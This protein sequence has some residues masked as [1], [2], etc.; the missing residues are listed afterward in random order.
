MVEFR[1]QPH[2][3]A[4]LPSKVSDGDESKIPEKRV[5]VPRNPLFN[6]ELIPMAAVFR[7]SPIHEE[8]YMVR[9][10]GFTLTLEPGQTFYGYPRGFAVRDVQEMSDGRYRA[11]L[12]GY[13]EAQS[14]RTYA[15]TA[16]HMVYTKHRQGRGYGDHPP[17]YHPAALFEWTVRYT[18]MLAQDYKV[19]AVVD[20]SGLEAII[21]QASDVANKHAASAIDGDDW[22]ELEDA[23]YAADSFGEALTTWGGIPAVVASRAGAALMSGNYSD[24]ITVK[25]Q[26]QKH[27]L[28]KADLAWRISWGI[29]PFGWRYSD[30]SAYKTLLGLPGTSVLLMPDARIGVQMGATWF[31]GER[32]KFE[33]SPHLG[34]DAY[35]K[36]SPLAVVQQVG[37]KRFVSLEGSAWLMW[38]VKGRFNERMDEVLNNNNSFVGLTA[39]LR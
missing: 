20:T 6:P 30:E 8:P 1:L 22:D 33:V 23:E 28:H 2:P 13:T 7:K 17:D 36:V 10:R 32:T 19:F 14:D 34:V 3:Y 26:W 5:E 18:P 31:W 37:N 16:Y 12:T 15:A 35:L 9:D 11:K 24:D 21:D 4:L 25:Q 38:G 27:K 29:P 39:R